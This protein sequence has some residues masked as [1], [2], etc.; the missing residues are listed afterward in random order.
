MGNQ[1]PNVRLN[2]VWCYQ[3][4]P[5]M[6][7]QF[8]GEWIDM[9][10]VNKII[11]YGGDACDGPEKSVGALALARETIARVLAVRIER[12]QMTESRA[13]DICRAWLYENPKRIYNL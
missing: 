6:T 3:I 2:L 4:S 9:V 11:A 5:Y 1:Y 10:P 7:E 8:L 13:M 12:K